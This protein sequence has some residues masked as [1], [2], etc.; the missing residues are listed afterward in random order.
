MLRHQRR[1]F[2]LTG[3]MI[4][5][6]VSGVAVSLMAQQTDVMKVGKKGTITFSTPTRI[7]SQTLPP[8]KYRVYCEHTEAGHQLVFIRLRERYPLDTLAT[9]E[10]SDITKVP[11]WM[12][13]MEN[14][15]RETV[16]RL[17]VDETGQR[18]LKQI[19]IRGENVRHVF[20]RRDPLRPIELPKS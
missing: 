6:F 11:C 8:A 7:G 19:L 15:A 10:T 20:W 12:E 1:S 16:L 9:S 5:L 2:A 18:Y 4:S 3:A 17:S 13:L 14:K